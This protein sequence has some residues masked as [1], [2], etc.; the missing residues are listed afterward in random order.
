VRIG[1]G[2]DILGNPIVGDPDMGAYEVQP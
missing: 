1:F 2:T